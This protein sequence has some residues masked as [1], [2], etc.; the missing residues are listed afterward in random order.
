[1]QKNPGKIAVMI[2][3]IRFIG[4]WIRV[5]IKSLRP[6]GAKAIAAENIVLCQQLITLSRQHKRSPL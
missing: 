5:T 6:G 4:G 3:A 1:M 2:N